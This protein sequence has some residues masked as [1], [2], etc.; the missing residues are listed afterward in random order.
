MLG[1]VWSPCVGPTLGA[2]IGLAA[3]GD[4]V[5]RAAAMMFVF[6]LGSAAPLLAIA[7]F[8]R[9]IVAARG[10]LTSLA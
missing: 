7:Y 1:A 6:G 2:A 9:R 3:T 5:G 4:S 8:S 10:R